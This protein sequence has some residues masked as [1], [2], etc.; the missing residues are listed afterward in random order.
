M[1]ERDRPGEQ[2]IGEDKSQKG[3]AEL[4]RQ[5]RWE[6]D[7]K[8]LREGKRSS[9]L[10]ILHFFKKSRFYNEEDRKWVRKPHAH[11]CSKNNE[12]F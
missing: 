11:H 8:A 4:R 7:G 6:G 2:K 10:S 9:R 12:H 3:F 1:Q 5:A